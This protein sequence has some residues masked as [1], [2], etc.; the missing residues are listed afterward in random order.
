MKFENLDKKQTVLRFILYIKNIKFYDLGN[1]IQKDYIVYI[2]MKK[3]LKALLSLSISSSS[4][5]SIN[6]TYT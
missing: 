3:N 1:F 4:F 2:T 6:K 5:L